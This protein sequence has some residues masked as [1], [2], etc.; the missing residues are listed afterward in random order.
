M[1]L[2]FEDVVVSVSNARAASWRPAVHLTPEGIRLLMLWSPVAPT[3][4]P[5]R[6]SGPRVAGKVRVGCHATRSYRTSAR[7][8]RRRAGAADDPPLHRFGYAFQ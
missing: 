2:T 3:Q 4:S 1:R 6:K 5:N 8:S 7:R